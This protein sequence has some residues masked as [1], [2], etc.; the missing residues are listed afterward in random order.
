LYGFEAVISSK[1]GA[2][3]WRVPGVLGFNFLVAAIA[4][5]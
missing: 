3:L 1:V 4:V 5:A 2:I